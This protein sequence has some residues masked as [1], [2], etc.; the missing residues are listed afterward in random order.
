MPWALAKGQDNFC[1][2]SEFIPK[3]IDPYSVEL[4]LRVNGQT[5]QQDLAGNMHFKIDEIIQYISQYIRLEE[6]DLLFTGTP[7]GVGGVKV[8]DHVEAFGRI[9][10]NIIAKLEFDVV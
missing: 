9:S 10:G 6:G 5:R 7:D 3:E 2:L 8:G 1:P 4:E